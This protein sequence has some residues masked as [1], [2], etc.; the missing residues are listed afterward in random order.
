MNH[1]TKYQHQ[2]QPRQRGIRLQILPSGQLQVITGKRFSESQIQTF[3]SAQQN[4][5]I[6]QQ[7]KLSRYKPI[8]V[9]KS[10]LD[11]FGK[12]YPISVKQAP[13]FQFR[14]SDNLAELSHPQ[15]TELKPSLL[16][17]KVTTFLNKTSTIYLPTRLRYWAKKMDI[18]ITK[19]RLA[20]QTS[21]WGS[22]SSTGTISLN[23]NLIFFDPNLSDYV[24]IHELA[25]RVHL[26]HSTKF[27][28]L[29]EK[30]D[31][32]YRIHRGQINR[33]R[34]MTDCSIWLAN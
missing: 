34:V 11:L 18:P 3:I 1:I 24:L 27:W 28:K 10:G 6:T 19:I 15:P 13:L 25:H 21:R 7:T 4:W 17:T 23:Q 33:Y 30:Y 8:G 20:R 26:N 14:L 9:T 12:L 32:E 22:C 16:Q 29:V 5:I 2:I 31:P